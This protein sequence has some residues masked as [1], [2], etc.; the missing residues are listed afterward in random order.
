MSR[1]F[2]GYTL[3]NVQLSDL[4]ASFLSVFPSF[5]LLSHARK[6]IHSFWGISVSVGLYVSLCLL[7]S[8]SFSLSLSLSLFLGFMR[9]TSNRIYLWC[10]PFPNPLCILRVKLS[11]YIFLP[12]LSILQVNLTRCNLLYILQHSLSYDSKWFL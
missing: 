9:R 6:V 7:L 5:I 2:T 4:P 12:F 3:V 11:T 10:T 8:P 1:V